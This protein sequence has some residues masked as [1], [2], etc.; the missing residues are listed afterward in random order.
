MSRLFT[1]FVVR[2][3]HAQEAEGRRDDHR[4]R[5]A[6]SAVTRSADEESAT[7]AALGLIA[8]SA[9]QSIPGVDFASITMHEADRTLHTAIATDS[10]A[11][12]ADALQYELCE[13]PCY[14]AVTDERL[15]LV[16]DLS[17]DVRF[18]RYAARVVDLGMRAQAAIQLVRGRRRAGLN[19]YARTPGSLDDSSMQ[20]AELFAAQA[21][22][23]LGYARQV[24]HLSEALAS[25]T[26]IGTA[27]GILMERYRIDRDQAFALLSRTSQQSN[28][29]VR[30]L[31]QRVI[32]GSFQAGPALAAGRA[33]AKSLGNTLAPTP[34]NGPWGVRSRA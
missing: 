5:G 9:A 3:L 16:D 27:I 1:A 13:G 21:G 24:E 26:D 22:A 14:A 7:E 8:T 28:I 11:E 20:Y 30:V 12:R 25:R 34:G 2:E 32:D 31:A 15:V 17:T 23:V 10:V 4:I 18:P 6:M 33:T 29:K 19:L